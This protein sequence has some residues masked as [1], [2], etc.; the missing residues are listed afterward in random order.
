MNKMP[1]IAA[2]VEINRVE[3]GYVIYQA[4][5]D[6]V[7]YLNHTAVVVLEC[8]TGENTVQQIETFVRNA[9]DL[10]KA[11]DTGV[12]PCLQNLIQEGLVYLPGSNVAIPAE[13]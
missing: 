5:R 4:S 6:R 7:H 3:D 10:D 9:F 12:Q 1:K 13:R 11:A 8:C 2:D